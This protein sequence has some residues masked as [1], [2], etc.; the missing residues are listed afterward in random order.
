MSQSAS[1]QRYNE[2]RGRLAYV[3]LALI[4][5]IE[6]AWLGALVFLGIKLVRYLFQ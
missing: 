1:I 4:P 3:I 2:T 5:I 6:I